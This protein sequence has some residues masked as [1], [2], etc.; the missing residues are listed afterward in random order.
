M[1]LGRQAAAEIEKTSTLFDDPMVNSYVDG[2]SQKIARNSD[3]PFPILIKV[4]Q[5]NDVNAF[6]LPGGFIYVTTGA[7]KAMNNEAE[8]AFVIGQM[9]GHVA[10]RHAT[11]LNSRGTL[12]QALSIPAIILNSS[13]GETAILQGQPLAVQNAMFQFSKSAVK[14]ADLLG[15]EYMYKAGYDPAAAVSFL[16]KLR[17]RNR[18][19]RSKA[20]CSTRIHRQRIGSH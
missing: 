19:Q 18:P 8:L 2:V 15:L 13:L 5:S 7:L 11:E 14:E 17:R 20:R 4:I 6:A 3:S 9:V 10:A 12:L 16:R 1:E